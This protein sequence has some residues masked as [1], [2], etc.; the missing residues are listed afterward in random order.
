LSISNGIRTDQWRLEPEK[1]RDLRVALPPLPEQSKI[2]ET[3]HK[4]ERR[5]VDL[6]SKT[7]AALAL[8]RERRSALVTAAVTGKID[9]RDASLSETLRQPLEAAE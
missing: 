5:L 7:D 6:I 2:A 1:L 4:E 8:L 9:V 3:I